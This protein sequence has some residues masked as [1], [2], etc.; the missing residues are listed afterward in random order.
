MLASGMDINVLILDTQVYSNTGGQTSTATFTGQDAK[1]SVV[2]KVLGGKTEKR[3]EIANL[4][5][6]HPDIFV[7]QT[8]SAHTNHFY[9]AIMAANEY[10]GPSVINVYTTCQPEH[11]VAD[12]MAMQQAKLAA[13]SRA[14]PIFIY[15]PSKGERISERL[16]LQGN[17][18]KN[19]D[20]Y[21]NPKTDEATDFITFARSEGR[22]AKHFDQNGKPDDIMK[23]SQADRLANWRLLQELAGVI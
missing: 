12:D 10:P 23:S 18:A 6:M 8:T 7:A 13:D 17:P 11:G 2:G 9:K 16:S 3:K 1:M 19:K 14:F 20:W 22:F 15:D 5:M 4:C 21:V